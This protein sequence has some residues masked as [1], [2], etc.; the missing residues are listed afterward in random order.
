MI[1][2]FLISICNLYNNPVQ[3]PMNQAAHVER[4]GIVSCREKNC[5][6]P[7]L[8]L[9]PLFPMECHHPMPIMFCDCLAVELNRTLWNTI[10]PNQPSIAPFFFCENS[11]TEPNHM[12]EFDWVRLNLMN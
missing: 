2:L 12:I 4:V 11:I 10:E 8:A 6:S 7:D 1:Y 5:I 3:N 9:P